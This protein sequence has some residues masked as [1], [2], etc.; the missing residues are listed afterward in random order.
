MLDDAFDAYLM[1]ARV[2]LA[3]GQASHALEMLHE[4]ELLADSG[5]IPRERLLAE[6]ARARVWLSSGQLANARSW[7]REWDPQRSTKILPSR[8]PAYLDWVRVQL[9]SD[10]MGTATQLLECL[11]LGAEAGGRKDIVREALVLEALVLEALVHARAGDG[12]A[13]LHVLEQL[14]PRVEAEGYIRLFLDEGRPMATL[15]R[16]AATQGISTRYVAQLLAIPRYS[17]LS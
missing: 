16:R 15:L 3:Q 6:A 14:L 17:I 8:E 5:Q 9:A 2:L 11:H 12:D 4:A 13:A 10:D 1:L 7:V